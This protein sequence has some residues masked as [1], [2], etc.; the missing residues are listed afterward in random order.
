MPVSIATLFNDIAPIEAGGRMHL[1]PAG[2]RFRA[3]D[4]RPTEVPDGWLINDQIG[5]ALAAQINSRRTPMVVDYE[6]A[7]MHAKGTGEPA[8]A[9]GFYA[10]AEWVPGAGLYAVD[11]DWNDRAAGYLSSREYRYSSAVIAYDDTTGAVLAVGPAAL[12]NDPALDGLDDVSLTALSAHFS[13]PLASLS[14]QETNHMDELLEQLRWLLNMPVGASADDITAQLKKL[15]AQISPEGGATVAT[16]GLSVLLAERDTKI[17]ELS[18]RQVD[19]ALYVPIADHKAL[20]DK[21]GALVDQVRTQ[22]VERVIQ[23]ALSAN[24][25]LPAQ[26][27]KARKL[28]AADPAAFADFLGGSPVIQ[29]LSTQ[30]TG[31]RQPPA[32]PVERTPAQV[33]ALARQYQ[34]EQAKV[35]VMVSAAAAVKHVITKEQ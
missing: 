31:G 17:A 33:A 1:L 30:Q 15:I 27:E 34:D 25:L 10:K 16:A 21:H 11:V 18:A 24:T 13:V 29:A 23:A 22:E 6:H 9:A 7:T 5:E 28:A 26:V 3:R 8:P 14:T 12:T 35:G 20:Q 19:L 4:G 2:P 32:K